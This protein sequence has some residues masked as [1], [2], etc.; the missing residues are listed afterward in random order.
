MTNPE[1]F[2]QLFRE[3]REEIKNWPEWMRIQDQDTS[4]RDVQCGESHTDD[5]D[6]RMSA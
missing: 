2:K 4:Q 6:E 3:A 1:T 5:A